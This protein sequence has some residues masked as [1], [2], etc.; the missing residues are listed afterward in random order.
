MLR[1]VFILNFLVLIALAVNAQISI[2]RQVLSSLGN[3]GVT[4][5]GITLNHTVGEAVIKTVSDNNFTLTQGFHQDTINSGSF[6]SEINVDTVAIRG[7]TCSNLNNG[8]AKLIATNF[9]K[10]PLKVEII[11]LNNALVILSYYTETSTIEIDGLPEGDFT[12]KV[13]DDNGNWSISE[14]FEINRIINP[15]NPCE[16]IKIWSAFTP[17]NDGIN[18]IWEIDGIEDYPL[19]T[20]TIFDRWGGKVWQK[21]GYLNT[22][23]QAFNGTNSNGRELPDGTYFYVIEIQSIDN[24]S[25]KGWVHILRPNK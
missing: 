25:R 19:N 23:E 2:E 7:V 21:E 6:P 11:D 24:P 8:F 4:K 22:N 10:L 16:D 12:V 3:A 14:P 9:T 15:S 18:D 5:N 17:D 13:T 20:I 1:T